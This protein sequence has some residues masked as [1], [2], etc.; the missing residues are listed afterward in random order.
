MSAQNSFKQ[1]RRQRGK[2]SI[3]DGLSGY[4]TTK[5]LPFLLLVLSPKSH[6]RNVHN[7][8]ENKHVSDKK[9]SDGT[10]WKS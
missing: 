10:F 2:A 8:R 7:P 1:Y 9:I 6:T 4:K 5:I 3:S